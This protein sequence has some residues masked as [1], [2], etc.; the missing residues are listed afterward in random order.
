MFGGVSCEVKRFWIELD[1]TQAYQT[2][3]QINKETF[4]NSHG[5]SAYG[6]AK[7]VCR[8]D[9]KW[10][11]RVIQADFSAG[12]KFRGIE[13]NFKRKIF[14][15]KLTPPMN[16]DVEPLLSHLKEL[17]ETIEKQPHDVICPDDVK[18]R[19]NKIVVYL[20]LCRQ[21][22]YK[23]ANNTIESVG[24]VF[25]EYREFFKKKDLTPPNQVKFKNFLS[26]LSKDLHVQSMT[27]EDISA[28]I[29][30]CSEGHAPTGSFLFEKIQGLIKK[31]TDAVLWPVASSAESVAEFC[32]V[33]A[34]HAYIYKPDADNAQA[35][36]KLQEAVDRLVTLLVSFDRDNK[37]STLSGF[38]VD[39]SRAIED[40]YNKFKK[41]GLEKL[42]PLVWALE[43]LVKNE[44][45]IKYLRAAARQKA[46]QDQG[47]PALYSELFAHEATWHAVCQY[48]I[49]LGN[50]DLFD[51]VVLKK[52]RRNK[53]VCLIPEDRLNMIFLH[54]NNRFSEEEDLTIRAE[55]KKM[56]QKFLEKLADAN[57]L[58][59]LK[60]YAK[61]PDHAATLRKNLVDLGYKVMND[62]ALDLELFFGNAAFRG[63]ECPK[64]DR[65]DKVRRTLVKLFTKF[66]PNP[67]DSPDEFNRVLEDCV[68]DFNREFEHLSEEVLSQIGKSTPPGVDK[69]PERKLIPVEGWL[70]TAVLPI[71]RSLKLLVLKCL[72]LEWKETTF[73]G[74]HNLL[75][76]MCVHDG[77]FYQLGH[78]GGK[79][80]LIPI[81]S[82]EGEVAVAEVESPAKV[83]F[84]GTYKDI[85]ADLKRRLEDGQNRQAVSHLTEVYMSS[86]RHK[87]VKE[88][89]EGLLKVL[90]AKMRED[91]APRFHERLTMLASFLHDISPFFNNLGELVI[92][93]FFEKAKLKT[94]IALNL[95]QMQNGVPLTSPELKGLKEGDE[96]VVAEDAKEALANDLTN[97]VSILCNEDILKILEKCSLSELVNAI[98]Q[99]ESVVCRRVDELS[100]TVSDF[101][102]SFCRHHADYERQYNLNEVIGELP[103][104]KAIMEEYGAFL[105]SRTIPVNFILPNQAIAIRLCQCSK[106]KDRNLLIK[107]GTGQG[108][109]IVIALAALKEASEVKDNKKGKVLVFTSYDHLARR[110]HDL[111][112]NFF[113]KEPISSICIS[114][115]ADVEQYNEDVKIIYADI[116]KIEDIIRDVMK[117]L[118]NNQATPAQK[119]FIKMIY[120]QDGEDIRIILDEY[121]LLLHDLELSQP[122]VSS[123]PTTMLDTGFVEKNP[124]YCPWLKNHLKPAKAPTSTQKASQSTGKEYRTVSW[125][126][127]GVGFNLPV[128][129]MRLSKLIG[130]AKRVIG[131]SGTALQGEAHHLNN[132]LFF[133]IPSSQNPNA[134]GTVIQEGDAKPNTEFPYI[135]R[136]QC[137]ELEE[138]KMDASAAFHLVSKAA[139]DEY[140][141]AVIEDIKEVQQPKEKGGVEYK[142][143]VLVFCDPFFM[144][145]TRPDQKDPTSLWTTLKDALQAAGIAVQELKSDVSDAELQTIARS[146][147]VTLSTIKYGRGADIRVS[148]DIPEGLHVLVATRVLHKRLLEQLIGRT[149][150]MGRWGSYSIVT[151]GNVLLPPED[152]AQVFSQYYSALHELTRF[153]I[154]KLL[155]KG[156]CSTDERK[157]WLMFLTNV[158]SE[159]WN[160]RKIKE[161]QAKALCGNKYEDNVIP[162]EFLN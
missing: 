145:K 23:K 70:Q 158:L 44:E 156:N 14:T 15:V 121:D 103:N 102:D 17:I 146:G 38:M 104:R 20:T 73:N 113:R 132:P 123:I 32:R 78:K 53:P 112:Q 141:R 92:Q 37:S 120:G 110:D 6:F 134:F 87:S 81:K 119:A 60:P 67:I 126:E 3:D 33:F 111:G 61:F 144:Y 66:G 149:G 25:Q 107:L 46:L 76:R 45:C 2:A 150:R 152:R 75:E 130:R 8:V 115:I 30:K 69:T 129:V 41:G 118:L 160:T 143:P 35:R 18:R 55:Y 19:L 52:I 42:A 84:T 101:R 26:Q 77:E 94:K 59:F 109:S 86:S 108:K 116:E 83:Q 95:K 128:S 11:V 5:Q 148:L 27:L 71:Y 105:R 96:V 99:F 140:C 43:A 162:K 56:M 135:A 10:G 39:V 31:G 138:P 159:R 50:Y 93:R 24:K 147:K 88:A 72:P 91:S 82:L 7:A 63:L 51:K 79:W 28:K 98:S 47:I 127:P 142:R 29:V 97:L 100:Y 21:W 68:M 40:H 90:F 136:R 1:K 22:P 117:N 49:Y 4:K 12:S 48:I 122:F 157:N 85:R 153:F 13:D 154:N 106:L 155:A 58:H 16:K 9:G 131:L 64:M 124:G 80:T 57:Q 89:M 139:V 62:A 114:S 137:R 125:Y 74:E 161:S 133:E 151:L 34:R 65:G 36:A 54:L